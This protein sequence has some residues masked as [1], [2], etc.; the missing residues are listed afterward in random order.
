VHYLSERERGRE[1]ETQSERERERFNEYSRLATHN[2]ATN[3]GHEVVHV[4]LPITYYISLSLSLSVT[5]LCE[6]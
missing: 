1:I 5:A 2:L 6:W 3:N 4:L